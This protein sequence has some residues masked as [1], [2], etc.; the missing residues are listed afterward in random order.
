MKFWKI[1]D[2]CLISE[3]FEA[4]QNLTYLDY[5]RFIENA[6]T[7]RISKFKVNLW[8]SYFFDDITTFFGL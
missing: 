1:A 2:M 7:L 8:I 4:S 6:Y 3:K 5:H